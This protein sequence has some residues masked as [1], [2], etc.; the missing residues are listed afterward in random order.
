MFP[1]TPTL[2]TL[3]LNIPIT[4]DDELEG[5]HEFTLI[6]TSV[7]SGPYAVIAAHSSIAT[8]VIEDDESEHTIL[9]RCYVGMVCMPTSCITQLASEL[10]NYIQS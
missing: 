8:V 2:E 5:D 4:R 1:V 9:P 6:I 3:C 7:G 10:T